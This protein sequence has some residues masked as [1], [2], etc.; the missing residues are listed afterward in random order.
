MLALIPRR[1][2]VKVLGFGNDVCVFTGGFDET[3]RVHH[4]SRRA[5]G[6]TGPLRARAQ[7][8]M[9]V[10]GYLGGGFLSAGDGSG[11]NNFVEPFRSGLR[12]IGFIE[13]HN[14]AVEYRWAEN[15]PER[16][17]ELAADLVRRRVAVICTFSNVATLAVRQATSE[18]PLVFVVGLFTQSSWALFQLSTGRAATPPA[19]HSLL[20]RWSQS[21]WSLC[22]YCYRKLS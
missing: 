5:R 4:A 21:G 12:E 1:P 10:I 18:I 3:T 17:P 8:T 16:L 6:D 15:R 7:Q 14:V 9:P 11:P 22:V 20:V 19:C 13:G 2:A